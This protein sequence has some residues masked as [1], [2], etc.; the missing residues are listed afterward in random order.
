ML[1]LTKV[2]N[3]YENGEWHCVTFHIKHT[4]GKL[5]KTLHILLEISN[6]KI[7]I[8]NK[9]KAKCLP[10]VILFWFCHSATSFLAASSACDVHDLKSSVG[11][12]LKFV[13]KLNPSQPSSQGSSTRI[14][15]KRYNISLLKF[16]SVIPTFI[17]A[18]SQT[19]LCLL[20]QTFKSKIVPRSWPEFCK[21][22]CT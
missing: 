22:F 11:L 16:K 10:R 20:V 5:L 21:R 9:S 4:F 6:R 19:F 2:V 12:L 8:K 17:N 13:Q 15:E 18:C 3:V 7:S 14:Q 1:E